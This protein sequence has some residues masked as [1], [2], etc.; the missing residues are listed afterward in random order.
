MIGGY[1]VAR[2]ATANRILQGTLFGLLFAVIDGALLIAGHASFEWLFVISNA[3][4]II[5]GT[6]GGAIAS[7]KGARR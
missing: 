4:R 6:I 5:G 3:G 2:S 1:L 7:R